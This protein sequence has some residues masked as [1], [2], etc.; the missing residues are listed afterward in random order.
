M[1]R[2]LKYKKF[3]RQKFCK[4]CERKA[5]K[6]YNLAMRLIITGA[7]SGIGLAIAKAF[8]AKGAR[9]AL[10]DT[11]ENLLAELPRDFHGFRADAA[12]QR[13]MENFMDGALSALGGADVLVN[14]AGIGGPQG[15]L[16]T[17]APDAWRNCVAVGVHGLFYAVRAAA[18]VMKKQKS[19]CIINMSSNAGRYPL[20]E[21]SPYVAAKW[22]VIGLTKTLAMELGPFGVRV[23]AIC[24][25]SVEGERISRVIQNDAAGRGINPEKVRAEYLRQSSL[26]RFARAEEI[27]AAALF[28]A[29]P[30]GAGISGQTIGID[31]HTE[32]L[33]QAEK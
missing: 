31:G 19:G 2:A 16:E 30:D 17:L 8:H 13:E 12:D 26:R 22:A 23:N 24:P 21:R 1:P 25:G 3:R 29:S 33:A 14:N 15:P 5:G 27:A 32:T 20:P 11:D 6:L 4:N 28:L 7:A 18:P 9:V 10:S